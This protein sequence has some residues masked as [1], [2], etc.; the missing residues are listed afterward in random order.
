M[1]LLEFARKASGVPFKE[2]GRDFDGWD[3]WGLIVAAYREVK[4]VTLP[5]FMY[6]GTDDYRALMKSFRARQD[7]YWR[8]V[9]AESM[10]I[11]CIYRRGHVIHAGLVLTSGVIM[12]VEKGIETCVER[13]DNF[14]IEGFYVPRD[15]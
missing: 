1:T 5:D 15:C 13:A 12:H 3:C 10:A 4:G 7:D 6:A 14:R 8:K 11:A 2:H 9:G